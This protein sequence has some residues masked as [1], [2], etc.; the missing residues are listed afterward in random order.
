M[1]YKRDKDGIYCDV[2]FTYGNTKFGGE[3]F[4][5][6]LIEKCKEKIKGLNEKNESKILNDNYEN[7]MAHLLRLKSRWES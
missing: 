6:I 7:N 2:K 5:N 3:D 4:D 1:R